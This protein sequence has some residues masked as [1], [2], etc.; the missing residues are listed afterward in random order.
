MNILCLP[1]C[2]P[3]KNPLYK[4][5][6]DINTIS[7]Y[8]SS[9]YVKYYRNSNPFGSIHYISAIVDNVCVSYKIYGNCFKDYGFDYF[10]NIYIS[11]RIRFEPKDGFR[12]KCLFCNKKKC[13]IRLS[14]CN[15]YCHIDCYLLHKDKIHSEC[16]TNSLS[17]DEIKL[18]SNDEDMCS[19]CLESIETKTECGHS[20]CRKCLDQIYYRHQGKTQCPI[21][22]NDLVKSKNTKL[23]KFIYENTNLKSNI[24]S[25]TE[26]KVKVM[27]HYT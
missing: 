3:N 11:K 25:M 20:L 9:K 2:K 12:N 13:S 21:C 5:D 6:I 10:I 8:I 22:R 1:F 7:E 19:V 14:C 4:N 16:C 23:L 18:L 26:Y 17:E 27:Y 24:I 15:K